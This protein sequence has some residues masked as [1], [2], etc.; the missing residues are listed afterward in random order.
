V[1][2]TVPSLSYDDRLISLVDIEVPDPGEG[3][4]QVTAA[5]CGICSW[6]I[7][8]CKLGDTFAFPAPAGHEGVGHVSKIGPGVT[9][10]HEGDRVAFG[11][12]A[13]LRNAP[14]SIVHK[15]PESQIPDEHW[16]VE[17]VS[18]VVTGIDHCHIK[19]GDRLVLIG[20]GFMGQLFL[21]GLQHTYAEQVVALDVDATRVDQARALGATEV[22]DLTKHDSADLGRELKERGIDVVIDTTGSQQGLDLATD[23]VRRGGTINL[24]GWIKGE[25]ASFDPSRWHLGGF[26]VVNSA[27]ASQIRDPF[28]AAIRLLQKGVFDLSQL[29]T[30]VVSVSEYP[31]LMSRILAGE[32]GYLKGVVKL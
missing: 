18:C 23:I 32:K 19:P 27:P 28:P 25:R 20:C 12:F 14:A 31:A 26:T 30:H 4:I 22:L 24:F 16:L 9:R 15:I 6:D 13:K 1:T 7:A 17:P 8:T 2:T 3:E 11:G 29:V 5:A 21:Q 10:F